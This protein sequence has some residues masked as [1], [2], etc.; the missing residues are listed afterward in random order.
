MQAATAEVTARL[1]AISSGVPLTD[2]I[3]EYLIYYAASLGGSVSAISVRLLS[4][5]VNVPTRPMTSITF[6]TPTAVIIEVCRY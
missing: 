4:I 5:D 2:A 3:Q 1:S 6:G